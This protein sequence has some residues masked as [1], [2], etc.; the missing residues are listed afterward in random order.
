MNNDSRDTFD[1]YTLAAA[2]L[3]VIGLCVLR[4]LGWVK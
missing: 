3:V 2:V 4:V 1:S